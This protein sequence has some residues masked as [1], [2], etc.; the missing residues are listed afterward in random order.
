MTKICA[1]EIIFGC[2]SQQ[3]MGHSALLTSHMPQVDNILSRWAIL[4][5]S[6][7]FKGRVSKA[8][9]TAA[10]HSLRGPARCLANWRLAQCGTPE[11][12]WHKCKRATKPGRTSCSSSQLAPPNMARPAALATPAPRRHPACH[13]FL[14]PAPTPSPDHHPRQPSGPKLCTHNFTAQPGQHWRPRLVVSA[15]HIPTTTCLEPPIG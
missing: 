7:C 9:G 4:L 15:Q 6:V 2:Y 11:L 13:Q 14:A 1:L 5:P 12:K 8:P 3:H 10:G